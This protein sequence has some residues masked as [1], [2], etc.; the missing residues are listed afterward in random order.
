MH[1]GQRWLLSYQPTTFA[2][3]PVILTA[4]CAGAAVVQTANRSPS[5]LFAVAERFAATHISGTPTFWRSFLLAAPPDHCRCNGRS[6]G[7]QLTSRRWI[8]W[9]NGFR[10]RSHT[11]TPRAKPARYFHV[12]DGHADFARVAGWQDRRRGSPHPRWCIEV[13]SPQRMLDYGGVHRRR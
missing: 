6:A 1:C 7:R 4:L 10:T 3:L 2:G 9:R 8:A 5:A 13:E 12:H 11:S